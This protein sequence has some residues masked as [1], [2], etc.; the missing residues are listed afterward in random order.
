[1]GC[2]CQEI[3]NAITKLPGGK[4]VV[5]MLPALDQTAPAKAPRQSPI[6]QSVTAVAVNGT[7]TTTVARRPEP[8]PTPLPAS[9][10]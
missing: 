7:T 8:A 2:K 1:M 10:E 6:R 5:A 3:R 9:P 4:F